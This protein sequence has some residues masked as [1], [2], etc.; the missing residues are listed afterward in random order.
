MGTEPERTIAQNV[1]E[2]LVD[3][4]HIM[5]AIGNLKYDMGVLEIW[6]MSTD[7]TQTHK[8]QLLKCLVRP[9]LKDKRIGT[10]LFS[11]RNGCNG[12]LKFIQKNRQTQ[13]LMV[14]TRFVPK[15]NQ[16]VSRHRAR[17]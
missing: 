15:S 17:W 5:L 3:W 7:M 1:G 11:R 6:D 8:S 10:Q 14:S 12:Q 2:C 4:C 9:N 16:N 13:I